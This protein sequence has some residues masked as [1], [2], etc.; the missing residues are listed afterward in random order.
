MELKEVRLV[1]E[2]AWIYVQNT[3]D[4]TDEMLSFIDD[5]ISTVLQFD[6]HY[7]VFIDGNEVNDYY[8]T[9]E[10]AE[11]H[12]EEWEAEWYENVEIMSINKK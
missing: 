8:L 12:K 7:S 5:I 9:R 6:K 11:Q 4:Y 10:I 2:N 3:N 1:K